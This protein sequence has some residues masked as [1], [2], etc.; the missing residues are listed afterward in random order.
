[1]SKYFVLRLLVPT[2]VMLGL[3][4]SASAGYLGS[5]P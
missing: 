5:V 2:V 3:A 4:L 1:M